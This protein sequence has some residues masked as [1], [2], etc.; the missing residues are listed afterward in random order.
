VRLGGREAKHGMGCKP[1][2]VPWR[3]AGAGPLYG[4]VNAPPPPA[5]ASRP[6]GGPRRRRRPD[7]LGGT[8]EREL[9]TSCRQMCA[10]VR[11]PLSAV[12][13][14]RPLLC[15]VD[16]AQSLDGASDRVLLL[17]SAEALGVEAEADWD[18]L[19]TPETYLG[20]LRGERFGSPDRLPLNHWALGGEWTIGPENVVLDE[21]GGSIASRFHARDA[22]RMLSRGARGSTPSACCSTARPR[23]R[24][25]RVST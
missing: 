9:F 15:L 11:A 7:F 3:R 8:S 18:H 13:E 19:H 24:H 16:D 10:S 5:R 17:V 22:R 23:G 20:H 12:A 25:M 6:S 14:E 1:E 4:A 21:A 2:E